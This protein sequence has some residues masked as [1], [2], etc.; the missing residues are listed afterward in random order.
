VL[1]P[2]GALVEQAHLGQRELAMLARLHLGDVAG[3][4]KSCKKESKNINIAEARSPAG[5]RGD[6][7]GQTRIERLGEN[8]IIGDPAPGLPSLPPSGRP[9]G[10]GIVPNKS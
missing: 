8:E 3:E 7:G 10:G 2:E 1:G 9:G 6:Q 5:W 4:E